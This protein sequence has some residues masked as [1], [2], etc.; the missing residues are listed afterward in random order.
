MTIHHIIM[1]LL[2][3]S[4]AIFSANDNPKSNFQ[5]NRI[6]SDLEYVV[7]TPKDSIIN[8]PLLILLHGYGSDEHDLFSFASQI[9]ENWLVISVRGTISQGNNRY[10]WY[11]V[12]ME[13]GKIT[14][15]F[16]EEEESRKQ[17]LAFIDKMTDT[18]KVD[19]QRVVVAGFSQGAAMSLNISLT[20][21]EKVAGFACF[22]GR[23]AEEITPFISQSPSLKSLRAFISHGTE[24][25]MLPIQYAKENIQ[26]LQNLG[27]TP[28]FVED[29]IAHSI[30]QKQ[31]GE[32]VKW[33][34]QF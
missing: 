1:L 28:V 9:P 19:K 26:M 21:P 14:L 10:C 23:F 12:G 34:N 33:L 17:L 22:S 25:K 32:F 13:K 2:G 24:D 30:S 31:L 8:P 27:I 20:S 18:Y 3:F 5:M 4:A 29:K 15:N 11:N 16:T 7:R 6:T